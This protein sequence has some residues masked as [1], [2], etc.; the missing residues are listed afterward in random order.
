MI[1]GHTVAA[2]I[3]CYRVSR[4][5]LSVLERVPES[6][7][8]VFCIDDACP[9]QSGRLIQST[10]RDPR[11]HVIFNES[12]QGVGGAVLRG[13]R[14]AI[15]SGHSILVKVDGDGQMDPTLIPLFVKPIADG[16]ADYTKG[17][18]FW[19]V[20][21]LGSMPLARRLGNLSLSFLSKVS[22]GYWDVFDP[23]NGYTAVHSKVAA[24]IPFDRLS[25]RYFFE[26]DML[27]R[28]GTLRAVVQDVPMDPIYGD[29]SSSLSVLKS[30]FEFSL[31][32][33]RNSLKRVIYRY[34]LRD[35][36]VASLELMFGLAMLL[37]GATFGALNW[38]ASAQAGVPTPT[39]TIVL[40]AV[41]L[42]SGLQFLLAFVSYDVSSVPRTPIHPR[43]PSVEDSSLNRKGNR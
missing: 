41:A 19:R 22:T 14:A 12:N 32:H 9:E 23:T 36:S 4:N 37:F 29:E 25:K 8:A 35:F 6:V 40:S 33:A 20:D 42:L 10:T 43:L 15:D 17:N 11:V 28:L 31:S 2:I 34:F 5:V 18:R 39:G 27:F 26:T 1:N 7:D 13:Y 21:E 3:P 30:L 38:A 16:F 24:Q